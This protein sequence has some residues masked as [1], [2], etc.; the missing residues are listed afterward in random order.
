[1]RAVRE[2]KRHSIWARVKASASHVS[3]QWQRHKMLPPQPHQPGGD[4]VRHDQSPKAPPG[5][6]YAPMNGDIEASAAGSSGAGPSAS[7]AEATHVASDGYTGSPPPE[8]W[9]WSL[10]PS[11]YTAQVRLAVEQISI[12]DSD[13]SFAILI[14][15]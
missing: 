7:S 15:F 8:H 13:G 5:I 6:N 1:M 3:P 4:E 12:R 2:H 11:K 9:T 14:E 10:F